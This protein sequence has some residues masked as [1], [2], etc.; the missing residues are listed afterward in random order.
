MKKKLL[1][2]TVATFCVSLVAGCGGDPTYQITAVPNSAEK[3]LVEGSGRYKIGDKVTLKAYPNVGCGGVPTLNFKKQNEHNFGADNEPFSMVAADV[4]EGQPGYYYAEFN[5]T[6][7]N[8]GTYQ[9]TFECSTNEEGNAADDMFK[10]FTVN[11][12]M[13]DDDNNPMSTQPT[14]LDNTGVDGL[15]DNQQKIASGRRLTELKYID[16]INDEII[17]HVKDTKGTDDV[18]DDTYEAFNFENSI[19]EDMTL[20]GKKAGKEA[21]ELM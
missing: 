7:E 17:W 12:V 19:R 1:F 21:K 9:L 13:V 14:I 10:E 3:G 11:Y 16:S 15:E 6:E 2:S 18:A 5:L 4:L 8:V 20:Y